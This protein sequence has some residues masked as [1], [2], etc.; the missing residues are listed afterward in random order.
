MKKLL[1]LISLSLLWVGA[2]SAHTALSNSSP[3]DGDELS[4]S[5]TK[6]EFEFT[7]SVR[8]LR[9]DLLN[10]QSESQVQVDIG[11]KTPSS[12]AEQHSVT[13]PELSPGTY[14]VDWSVMGADGHPVRGAFSFEIKAAAEPG[15]DAE[16]H[17]HDAH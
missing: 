17:S 8:L 15:S 6:I 14:R 16:K 7:E 11:F 5:P 13:V 1:L 12:A 2:A 10:V 3:S 9:A 4:Q